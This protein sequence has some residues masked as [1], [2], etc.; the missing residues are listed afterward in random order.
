ME[1]HKS[2]VSP[3]RR[4]CNTSHAK[5][6][7]LPSKCA[8]TPRPGGV[9]TQRI[10]NSGGPW[11]VE[12]QTFFYMFFEPSFCR[13]FSGLGPLLGRLGAALG[14]NLDENSTKIA[15]KT[16]VFDNRTSDIAFY[17]KIHEK[18]NV[19]FHMCGFLRMCFR[20]C[21]LRYFLACRTSSHLVCLCGSAL[22]FYIRFYSFLSSFWG[23]F[24]G[25][26]MLSSVTLQYNGFGLNLA[27]P[28]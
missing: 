10:K 1:H 11:G 28:F 21:I 17:T 9:A 24:P 25:L 14:T 4:I 13:S 16:G 26:S 15:S 6:T 5:T 7:V 2:R 8:K 3:K 23:V 12:K 27:G 18:K 19:N 20:T 22:N